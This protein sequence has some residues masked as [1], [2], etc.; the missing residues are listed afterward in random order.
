MHAIKYQD[1]RMCGRLQVL[2]AVIA[3]QYICETY[4]HLE[5]RSR[6]LFTTKMICHSLISI[7]HL[8][9]KLTI[10]QL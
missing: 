10:T 7:P 3:I 2:L 8:S 4:A 6:Y 9:S 1:R 5:G